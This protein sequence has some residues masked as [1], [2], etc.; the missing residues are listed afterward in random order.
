MTLGWST[1]SP[2]GTRRSTAFVGWTVPLV[3]ALATAA[4]FLPSVQNEFLE[5]DDFGAI[6]DNPTYRGLGWPQ[7]KWMW[8]SFSIG[9]YRPLTWMTF[10]ADYLVWGVDSFG[11]HLSSLL[12]HVFAAVVVYFL[13]LR[14]L[15]L[16]RG[17][18]APSDPAGLAVAAG[19]AALFFAIH[20]LRAEPV[21]WVSARADLVAG[22]LLGLSTL[23]YL[24]ACRAPVTARA[25]R[26]WLAAAVGLFA[27]SLTAKPTNLLFPVV[28][29]V[30]DAYPLRRLGG[31][32]GAWLGTAVRHVWWEKVPFIG[33]ACVVMPVHLVARAQPGG[34]FQWD[35]L[36]GPALAVHGLTF[37]LRKTFLLGALSPLYERPV[38][39]HPLA[40]PIL[41]SG[42]AVFLITVLLVV[43]RRRWPAGLAAWVCYVALLAPSSGLIPFGRHLAADRYTYASC[44]S[45]A[46]LIGGATLV[47]W[48]ARRAGRIGPAIFG[49]SVA[50]IG[51]ALA[52]L[53]VLTWQ[54][55]QVWRDSKTLWAHVI[56]IDPRS[57]VAHNN[58]GSILEGE[59]RLRDA[60]GHYRQAVLS[61][62]GEAPF[63]INLGLAL[64]AQGRELAREGRFE[65]AVLP[66]REA[67]RVRPDFADAHVA[68]GS[69][70][71]AQGHAEEG[72]AQYRRALQLYP[73]SA[74]IHYHLGLALAG[75]GR[76]QE[77][78]DHYRAA[79]A[80]RPDF[81]EARSQ[82]DLALDRLRGRA[83]GPPRP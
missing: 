25:R 52:G 78:V 64:I 82:L 75:Q 3:V 22:P 58:L 23:A 6:R 2:A 67:L 43:A 46:L 65:D 44:V 80:A 70:L 61:R 16:S 15:G 37:Y 10:A 11:F 33:I 69:V 59:G 50:L 5:W 60:V 17:G 26:G 79:L 12:F 72:I 81:V 21:A 56:A 68:L 13:A 74:P 63:T 19:V 55:V 42:I 28:L 18:V 40:G 53:G 54:Q 49:L 14:L 4:V 24:A 76:L 51:V 47:W 20:P 38:D 73:K 31:R 66:L 32:P 29:T 8:T 48:R 77:A 1:S 7:L 9:M 62:P 71:I 30:L 39:F 57:G 35:P 41:S 83:H 36:L 34:T 27:A 45:W